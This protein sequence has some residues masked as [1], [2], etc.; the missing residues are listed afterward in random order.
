MTEF[1]QTEAIGNIMHW[2]YKYCFIVVVV[3]LFFMFPLMLLIETTCILSFRS[4]SVHNKVCFR[5][6]SHSCLFADEAGV[7]MWCGCVCWLRGWGSYRSYKSCCSSPEMDLFVK[8]KYPGTRPSCFWFLISSDNAYSHNS[9]CL[10]SSTM[11]WRI[12]M[13]LNSIWFRRNIPNLYTEMDTVKLPL[14]FKFYKCD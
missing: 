3:L 13:P 1:W 2:S 8:H 9:T 5:M 10:R 6:W 11:F 4:H 14:S 7:E 12:L